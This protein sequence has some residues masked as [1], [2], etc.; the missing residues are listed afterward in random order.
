MVEEWT[1]NI[2]Y[3]QGFLTDDLNDIAQHFLDSS[4]FS[5]NAGD[6]MVL[7]ISNI[8]QMPITIF[9]SAQNM[10][11]VCILPTTQ[12]LLSTHPI[13][14]AYTQDSDGCPKVAVNAHI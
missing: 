14:L 9:T 10:P 4:Q 1:N 6:L 5:G 12:T 11:L 7:T 8:L 3:Y 2:E 13:C